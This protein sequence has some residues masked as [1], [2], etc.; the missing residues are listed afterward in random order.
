MD[1]FEPHPTKRKRSSILKPPEKRISRD[2][3]TVSFN[4][5]CLY[6]ETHRDGTSDITHLFLCDDMDVTMMETVEPT[7]DLQRVIDSSNMDISAEAS[8]IVGQFIS[9]L[10]EVNPIEIP[11][12]EYDTSTL[13]EKKMSIDPSLNSSHADDANV[14]IINHTRAGT[15]DSVTMSDI[16]TTLQLNASQNSNLS[17]ANETLYGAFHE[18]NNLSV[19]T[20]GVDTLLHNIE[21]LHDCIQRVEQEA[22]ECRHK[23]D[24]EIGEIFK[25]Y[26][27]IV[28]KENKYEFAVRIFGLRYGLWLWLKINPETYPNEKIRLKF[29]VDKRDKHM[30]PFPEYAEAVYRSTQVGK[31]Y[32]TRIIINAQKFRRFLRAIGFRKNTD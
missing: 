3:R 22:E 28:S 27:H 31:G 16:D 18:S 21:A 2:S 19:R 1:V 8:V 5:R 20:S 30:Y 25:F 4:D 10:P 13:Y 17:L 29:A 9:T 32:L 12:I 26:R 24:E 23:L 11:S 14:T 15:N 7:I 6:K